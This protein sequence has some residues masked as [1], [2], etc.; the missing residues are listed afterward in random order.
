MA[1]KVISCRAVKKYLFDFVE[2]ELPEDL[3]RMIEAHIGECEACNRLV[4]SYRLSIE[5]ARIR[6][7]RDE[8][9]PDECKVDIIRQLTDTID[10][11]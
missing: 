3:Q 9:M 7:Q 10:D 6:L 8:K 11:V 5:S 4:V 2:G 1:E